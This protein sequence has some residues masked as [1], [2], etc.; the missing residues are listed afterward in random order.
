MRSFRICRQGNIRS[1]LKITG[2]A[3]KAGRIDEIPRFHTAVDG[4]LAPRMNRFESIGIPSRAELFSE[5]P[6]AGQR[7]P[8]VCARI[9]SERQLRA[10]RPPA[11]DENQ[12][13]TRTP[14]AR[15]DK[16]PY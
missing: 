16:R 12:A 9:N 6:S 13:A 11:A 10:W 3:K 15:R 5:Y 14:A 2:I 7:Y 8:A 4:I 1:L